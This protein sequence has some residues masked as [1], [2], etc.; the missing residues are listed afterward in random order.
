MAKGSSGFD[1]NGS[2]NRNSAIGNEKPITVDVMY[3]NGAYYGEVF[4]ATENG[5]GIIK[6]SR[7][8]DTEWEKESRTTSTV[9]HTLSS[10]LYSDSKRVDSSGAYSSYASHNINWDKVKEV[11]GDTYHLRRLMREKGFEWDKNKKA[12]VKK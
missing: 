10:G 2:A 1:K 6:I 12:W 11:S 7:N 3:R 9:H 8:Q 4:K 5:D